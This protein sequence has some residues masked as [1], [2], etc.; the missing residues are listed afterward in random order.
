MQFSSLVNK[1]GLVQDTLFM[2][3]STTGSYPLEEITRNINSEYH[4][5]NRLIWE[6]ADDWHFDDS[7]KTDL[8]VST[9]DLVHNQQ[10]YSIPST[11]QRIRRVEVKD[12]NGNY[13]KLEPLISEDIDGS[14]KEFMD[15][16]GVPV[17]YDLVD[18]SI[19]L[20]PKPSSASVTTTSGL[21]IYFDRDIS[22]FTTAST[23]ASP[24]FA[25][26]FHRILSLQAAI[27]FTEDNN[28]IQ[29][30]MAEKSNLIEG[31]KKFYGS[32]SLEETTQIRPAGR[33]YF[34]QYE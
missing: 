1:N 7:N 21:D 18:A 11:A 26:P 17:Y 25:T 33:R 4:N 8:P 9:T 19:F 14:L 12:I 22:E 23:T 15:T 24:G 5:V 20:Y 2:T 32:R 3:R 30:W 28:K 16:P 29:L 13:T 27:D 10:D 31:L 34:R 6:S